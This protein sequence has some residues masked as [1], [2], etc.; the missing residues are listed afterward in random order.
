M[1]VTYSMKKVEENRKYYEMMYD[2][3][4]HLVKIDQIMD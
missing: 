1:Y 4:H 2:A 3:S